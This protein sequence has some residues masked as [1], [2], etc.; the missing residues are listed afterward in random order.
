MGQTRTYRTI[1]VHPNLRP[2]PFNKADRY[3]PQHSSITDKG[4]RLFGLFWWNRKYG[5]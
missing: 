5:F 1:A 2:T 4:V 3:K